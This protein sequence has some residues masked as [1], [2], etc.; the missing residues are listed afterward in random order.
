MRRLL[1][2]YA[3]S[4]SKRH[5]RYGHLFQNRYKLFLCEEDPYL[6][7]LVRYIHLSP[8]RAGIVSDEPYERR[9]DAVAKG[10]SIDQ[11]ITT[12]AEYLDLDVESIEKKGTKRSIA[13]TQS[14]IC[15][16]AVDRLMLTGVDIAR[17][18]NLTPSGVSR[19]VARGRGELALHELEETLFGE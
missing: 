3:I 11:V 17:K 5:K 16:L 2:G 9:T 18:L 13:L 10:M 7:E 8:L 14:I 6:L 4:F 15:A 1:T 12:V 19:L